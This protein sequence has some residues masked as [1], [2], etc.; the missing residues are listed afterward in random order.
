MNRHLLW[1]GL[2]LLGLLVA[3]PAWA[4]DQEEEEDVSIAD[5]RTFVTYYKREKKFK[6]LV[7][8]L[9]EEL[10]D[11]ETACTE[12]GDACDLEGRLYILDDLA[13]VYTYGLVDFEKAK[14][15]NAKTRELYDRIREKGLDTLPVSEYFNANRFLYY[16]FYAK[17][18]L[19]GGD[20][21]MDFA[22]DD[23]YVDSVRKSDFD[24]V[25]ARVAKRHVFLGEKLGSAPA[26]RDES[27]AAKRIDKDLFLLYTG[28][29]DASP[30]YSPFE[31]GFLKA[32]MAVQALSGGQPDQ[33]VFIDAIVS[34]QGFCNGPGTGSLERQD[35]VNRLNY[36]LT[37]A[38]MKKGDYQGALVHHDR[39]LEGI[40]A[41][42][43]MTVKRYVSMSALLREQYRAELEQKNKNRLSGKKFLAGLSSAAVVIAKIGATLM[44]AAA[45]ASAN[46]Q[47]G[48]QQRYGK[49][50][51]T[52]DTV[53]LLWKDKELDFGVHDSIME[54]DFL[55][56]VYT[57]DNDNAERFS[58]FMAPYTLLLNRYLNKYEL[59]VYMLAIGDAY[60]VQ[61][62]LEQAAA[63]Y[64][65]A[66]EITERQRLTIYSE[67]ERVAYFGFKQ[68]LYSKMIQTLIGLDQVREA[69]EY[70]E[71][72][73][74][75]AFL[76][77]LGGDRIALKSSSQTELAD[78]YYQS[79]AEVDSVL[80][81]TGIGVDQVAYAQETSL[82]GLEIIG[83]NLDDNSYDE[84]YSLSSVKV[85]EADRIQELIDNHTAILEYYFTENKLNIMVVRRDGVTNTGVD[86]DQEAL[87]AQIGDL[88]RSVVDQKYDRKL[89]RA[90]YKVLVQPVARQL[91]C[92]RLVIIPHRGL[93]YLPFHALLAGNRFLVELYAISYAPSATALSIVNRKK[94]AKDGKA[95]VVGNP[96]GDLAYSEKEAAAI[97]KVL[98]DAEV[99][100]GDQG[101]ETFL[102]RDAGEYKII[103][104]ASHG[105]FD[106]EHPLASRIMLFPTQQDDGALMTD[107]LFSCRWRASLVTLSA[108]QTGVSKYNS[109]DELIGLQRGVFFAGTQS[110][111]A[112]SWKV[113]DK[114]TSY[115]MT[116]FY[117][118]LANNPKDIAL[119]KA[120]SDAIRRYGQPFHWASFRLIGAS[121]RVYN[122]EYPLLVSADPEDAK[123]ILAGIRKR[124]EP[125]VRLPEGKYTIRV[126]K[127]GYVPKEMEVAIAEEP[128][129]LKV[130]LT[131]ESKGVPFRVTVDPQDARV[132]F[133]GVGLKY[134]PGMQIPAGK[135]TVRISK[136]GYKR[137]KI[138]VE[139]K[140]E[141]VEIK[142]ELEKE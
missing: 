112:S 123:I 90:L 94:F 33:D 81:T 135:Y 57:I 93:H 104:I 98:P 52:E 36:W 47:P 84:I 109:G 43:D 37:L 35:K 49:S 41:M 101:T 70:V 68:A 65:E 105:V 53:N 6:A 77:I 122:P 111:L 31:K 96:T 91:K 102:K 5:S 62:D 110:L 108:C 3:M 32:R 80:E 59:A 40:K 89:A 8:L 139:I 42:E 19:L 99:L 50:T 25:L 103:H 22:F 1:I 20:E 114:S 51:L 69:L 67:R 45:D 129:K 46:S 38:L 23:N 24:N 107:E 116:R 92:D 106:P 30:T 82:R 115:L 12:N 18:P 142:V 86:V 21:S 2:C 75:R 9:E 121:N 124:Y 28:F 128:V 74:S 130:S 138:D 118:H 85:L 54:A 39:F 58:R 87:V 7:E 44:A 10:A 61:G 133:M 78:A 88:R 55:N 71:R 14:E 127:K 79:R 11:I 63:Q 76:D 131:P 113:D 48:Y 64:R 120:Q 66:I 60:T 117:R 141:A 126:S 83:K 72:S 97:G 29:I 13:D 136:K 134:E 27:S 34:A 17:D 16:A 26:G 119:Q 15:Y 95:L 4:G 100:L 125:N 132:R 137:Q 73:K 140:D 56:P